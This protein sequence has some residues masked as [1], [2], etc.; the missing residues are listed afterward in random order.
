MEIW[1]VA[2]KAPVFPLLFWSFSCS[3]IL[4]FLPWLVA[5]TLS[6]FCT[7]IIC[8][9]R[10]KCHRWGW[11]LVAMRLRNNACSYATTLDGGQNNQNYLHCLQ[12]GDWDFDVRYIIIGTTRTK[13]RA[14]E[15]FE[16]HLQTG[17]VTTYSWQSGKNKCGIKADVLSVYFRQATN[18]LFLSSSSLL[19]FLC[20][21][22]LNA[23]PFKKLKNHFNATWK[24]TVR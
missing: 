23:I 20:L 5:W 16:F 11:T 1:F 3:D 2:I 7:N 12:N 9:V 24:L 18:K 8:C 14:K 6:D 17:S 13:F 15:I 19:S 22:S 21:L 4:L 10:R